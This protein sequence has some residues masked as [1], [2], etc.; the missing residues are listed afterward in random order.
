[1]MLLGAVVVIL[2]IVPS[3]RWIW[4]WFKTLPGPIRVGLG[5]S[6]VGLGILFLNL[7]L[8]RWTDRHADRAL[9]ES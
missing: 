1:M 2:Y 5:V 6:V 7:L 8:E 4:L 3:F 9:R